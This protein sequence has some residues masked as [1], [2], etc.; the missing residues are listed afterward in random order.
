MNELIDF[1]TA[2]LPRSEHSENR[3]VQEI[4]YLETR[5][6]DLDHSG[7]CAYERSLVRTY[8]ALLRTR[9]TQLAEFRA[10]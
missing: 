4:A 1:Y 8:A 6:H 3:L 5:L 10:A 2:V 9:R 7:D